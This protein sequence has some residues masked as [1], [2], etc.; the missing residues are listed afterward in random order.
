MRVR[1]ATHD[2]T[3]ARFYGIYLLIKKALLCE[4]QQKERDN[5]E[6]FTGGVKCHLHY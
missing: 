5:K 4:Q 2:G 3:T 1:S 6:E